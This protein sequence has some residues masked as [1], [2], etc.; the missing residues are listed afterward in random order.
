MK[1]MKIILLSVG[2]ENSV[3][4]RKLATLRKENITKRERKENI[5]LSV[6]INNAVKGTHLN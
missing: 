5:K 3:K 1:V 6:K 4:Q 2:Y